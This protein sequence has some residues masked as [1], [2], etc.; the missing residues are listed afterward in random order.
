MRKIKFILIFVLLGGLSW[1]LFIKPHDYIVRFKVNTS[2]GALYSGVEEWSLLSQ[3]QDTFSYKIYQKHPYSFI[4]EELITSK[5]IKL[6]ID[7]NFKSKTDTS[8]QVTVG[9]L[10]KENSIYNRLTVPFTNTTF[11]NTAL[12]LV[13]NFKKGIDYQLREKFKVTY[14]GIDTIP[15][16]NYAYVELRNVN[17]RD[18]AAQMMKHNSML[19]SFLNE[20]DLK[21]SDFPFLVVSNWDKDKNTIDFRYCFQVKQV[22]SLPLHKDI[23]FDKQSSGKALKAIYNGNYITSDRGWFALHEYA[24]RHHIVI[25]N[26]P[27]EIFFDNPFYGGTELNWKAEVFMP[28]KQK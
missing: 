10:E 6:E 9:F 5:G 3:K 27:F 14:V 2:P 11:K 13:K 15:E 16:M 25:E 28:I 1:Y 24:K 4:N 12:Q 20:H 23:K 26:T 22:D 7:W 17:M 19:I 8:T 18:K 21:G